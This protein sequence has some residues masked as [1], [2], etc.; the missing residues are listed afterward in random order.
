MRVVKY[1]SG[2]ASHLGISLY[3]YIYNGTILHDLHNILCIY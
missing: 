3:M 1:F 2:E